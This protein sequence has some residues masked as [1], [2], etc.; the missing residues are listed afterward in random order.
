M[1]LAHLN[2][3]PNIGR[4]QFHSWPLKMLLE[5][6][7]VSTGTIWIILLSPQQKT[8]EPLPRA[9]KKEASLHMHCILLQAVL[10]D[11]LL[12]L[13][14]IDWE[15][16]PSALL[17]LSWKLLK[18]PTTLTVPKISGTTCINHVFSC[19]FTVAESA[20]IRNAMW[21]H[22]VLFQSHCQVPSAS[23]YQT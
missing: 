9:K 23:Q 21:V 12:W 13:W 19:A 15:E 10:Q 1:Y 8:D 5:V 14:D 22:Q 11:T 4:A 2:D 16:M 3:M 6:P 17:H 20:H 7:M 18:Y